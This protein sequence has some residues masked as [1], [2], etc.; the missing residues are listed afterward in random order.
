VDL[1]ESYTKLNP[2][3]VPTAYA[4]VA[5]SDNDV[6]I[7]A[8]ALPDVFE[9]FFTTKGGRAKAAAPRGQAVP[10]QVYRKADKQA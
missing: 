4:T 1:D 9:P 2:D 5:V 6:G 10:A 7:G 3:V 8:S